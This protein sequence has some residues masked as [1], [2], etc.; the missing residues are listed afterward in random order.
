MLEEGLD[1]ATVTGMDE[2]TQ[3]W[4]FMR[5]IGADP[6]NR[7]SQTVGFLESSWERG[8]YDIRFA[9]VVKLDAGKKA[10]SRALEGCPL[11]AGKDVRTKFLPLYFSSEQGSGEVYKPKDTDRVA[12]G[13]TI[14]TNAG[15]QGSWWNE[16]YGWPMKLFQFT[17]WTKRWPPTS[18]QKTAQGG[19]L[20]TTI[21][22]IWSCRNAEH[23]VWYVHL[24]A[25]KTQVES[26]NAWE[27]IESSDDTQTTI[28]ELKERGFYSPYYLIQRALEVV[29]S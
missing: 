14:T 7:K 18:L 12:M 20:Q 13:L 22:S 9:R 16:A 1:W 8:T 27:T 23:T 26:L 11:E 3:L 4:D 29:R 25:E 17:E 5:F 15:G 2:W 10:H 19:S 6:E 28:Q 21:D 24:N